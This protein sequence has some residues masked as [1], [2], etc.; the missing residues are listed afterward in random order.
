MVALVTSSMGCVGGGKTD[1][2]SNPTT[3][4]AKPAYSCAGDADCTIRD[5]KCGP[6]CVHKD[7]QIQEPEIDC[8][9]RP[10]F[11][12]EQCKCVNGSCTKI[13]CEEQGLYYEECNRKA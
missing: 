4:Y 13:S 7:Q 2:A 10:W 9:Y 8:E 6:E 12:K 1:A 5:A 11:A 3:T